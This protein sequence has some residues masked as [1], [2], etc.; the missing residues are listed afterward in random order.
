MS[1]HRSRGEPERGDWYRIKLLL[2]NGWV[3]NAAGATDW[4]WWFGVPRRS[5]HRLRSGARPIRACRNRCRRISW[6]RGRS[7]QTGRA[8]YRRQRPQGAPIEPPPADHRSD[9]RTTAV[10]AVYER[11]L[12]CAIVGGSSRTWGCLPYK[13]SI[14]IP[15]RAQGDLPVLQKELGNDW[16]FNVTASRIRWSRDNRLPL[17]WARIN[18]E[19]GPRQ[20]VWQR[21]PTVFSEPR[22]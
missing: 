11:E 19:P 3:L 17:P 21:P 5:P 8:C 6:Q 20:Y 18:P 1:K 14:R 15:E 10:A 4:R 12:P 7:A 2:A 9:P 13:R 22:S 16:F